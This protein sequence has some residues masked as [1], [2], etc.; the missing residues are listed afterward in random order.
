MVACG[1]LDPINRK[2]SAPAAP[3]TPAAACS[4]KVPTYCCRATWGLW[5]G[6]RC[7]WRR[8][9]PATKPLAPRTR[10]PTAPTS[11]G[12]TPMTANGSGGCVGEQ[13]GACVCVC[14]DKQGAARERG[15]GGDLG[16]RHGC[17]CMAAAAASVCR[18]GAW[19][20]L[21]G[22]GRVPWAPLRGLILHADTPAC[23]THT[24]GTR[25]CSR[26]SHSCAAAPARPR[27][28]AACAPAA[29]PPPPCSL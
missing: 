18:L 4:C 5:C 20:Q 29:P 6:C 3:A 25:H 27:P 8:G 19:Q 7:L 13:G 23:L 16:G 17:A 10:P 26:A 28:T 24:R 14:G 12:H 21:K 9:T 2:P 1:C 11:A 15:G 22:A